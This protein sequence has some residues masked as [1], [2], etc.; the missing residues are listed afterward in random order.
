MLAAEHQAHRLGE[1]LGSLAQAARD[2]ATM[3]L[4]VEAGRARTRTS[5]RVI[6]GVTIALA[7]ALALLNQTYLEPYDSAVGQLVL[8]AIGVAFAA[9][10]IWLARMTKPVRPERLPGSDGAG[11][12]IVALLC[13]AT[14]GAG[15]W[16]VARGWCPPR[17]S[18]VQ[19]LALPARRS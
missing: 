16:L 11:R 12:M 3:R 15:L 9:G 18:L 10:F 6:V 8:L 1:L 19:A 5:V 13:G 14:A 4:R 7:A 17:P 2:Q